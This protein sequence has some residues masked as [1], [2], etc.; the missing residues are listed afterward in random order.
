MAT[1]ER[2]ISQSIQFFY[3]ITLALGFPSYGLGIILFTIAIKIV[4]LPLT[5][6]QVRAMRVMQILQPEVQEIQ[7]KHKNNPQKSQQMIMD[8]YKKHN[9]NP[10]SGCWPILVQMPIL[11]AMFKALRVFFDPELAP[12]YVNLA[13]AGFLWIPNLGMPDPYILPILVALGTFLQQKVT[14]SAATLEQNPSQK[15]LLYFM[16][17]FIGWISRTFPAALALYWLMYS[18]VGIFEQ[19]L[20][21]RSAAKKEEVGSK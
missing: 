21:K 20:L 3:E 8:L 16:P 15:V 5:V 7:K 18:I 2:F 17:L 6:K 19:M 10:F 4:L 9:A 12:D 14:M 13:H 1:L 11:F